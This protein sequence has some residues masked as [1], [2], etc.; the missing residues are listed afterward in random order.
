MIGSRLFD[1]VSLGGVSLVAALAVDALAVVVELG[2]RSQQAILEL[3]LL[4][5]QS[6]LRG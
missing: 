2:R 4:A 1:S 3:F 5:P 6:R